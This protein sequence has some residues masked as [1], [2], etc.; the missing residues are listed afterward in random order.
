MSSCADVQATLEDLSIEALDPIQLH[1]L[2][3]RVQEGIGTLHDQ[4]HERFFA[5]E[6][7]AP[8]ESLV[9]A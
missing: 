4:V 5:A 6:A 7:T 8:P 3:E 1:D 9:P 2:V